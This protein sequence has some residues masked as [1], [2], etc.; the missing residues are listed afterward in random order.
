[1]SL[2]TKFVAYVLTLLL[3]ATLLRSTLVLVLG[4]LNSSI[5]LTM[6]VLVLVSNFSYPSTSAR[7]HAT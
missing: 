1:V 7:F 2:V 5:M 3:Q 6:P 4:R